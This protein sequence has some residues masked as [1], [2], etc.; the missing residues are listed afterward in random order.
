MLYVYIIIAVI[1]IAF[2]LNRLLTSPEERFAKGLARAQLISILLVKDKYPDLT[3][4]DRFREAIKTR[5]GYG[6]REVDEIYEQVKQAKGSNQEVADVIKAMIIYEYNTRV[7]YQ[8][9]KKDIGTVAEETVA[10]M[11]GKK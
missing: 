6:D 7:G 1:V 9:G 10:K 2:V 5:P 3:L 4:E 8:R 11:F